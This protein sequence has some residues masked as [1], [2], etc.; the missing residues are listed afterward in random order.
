MRINKFIATKTAY[1][2]RKA[3]ELIKE[4]KVKI[5]GELLENLAYTIND[6]AMIIDF[7]MN[8]GSPDRHA[9]R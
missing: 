1:S 5:N 7:S 2:R 3:D 4:K 9:R 8:S 6:D